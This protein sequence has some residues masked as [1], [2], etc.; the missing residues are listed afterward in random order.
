M[1]LFEFEELFISQVPSKEV[2]LGII[3]IMAILTVAMFIG[4]WWGKMT[5]EERTRLFKQIC[6]IVPAFGI[7]ALYSF[8]IYVI[9]RI[10][11]GTDKIIVGIRA[12]ESFVYFLIDV[13]NILIPWSEILMVGIFL[14]WLFFGFFITY[15][16]V[17]EA[18]LEK[19]RDNE[20]KE[21]CRK[22]KDINLTEKEKMEIWKK[23][24]LYILDSGHGKQVDAFIIF[25]KEQEGSKGEEP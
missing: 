7:W 23:Y 11:I 17:R 4:V 9:L 15:Y 3:G 14:F 20:F 13:T 18:M 19:E 21:D 2:V 22:Y 8:I 16:D 1:T 12:Y 5:S 10:F 25:L 6:C 24:A